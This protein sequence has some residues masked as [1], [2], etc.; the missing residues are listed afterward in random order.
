MKSFLIVFI[1]FLSALPQSFIEEKNSSVMV[2]IFPLKS[3]IKY[4]YF[5]NMTSSSGDEMFSR[6]SRDSGKVYYVVIDSTALNDTTIIWD[7]IQIQDFWRTQTSNYNQSDT[8]FK[9]TDSIKLILYEKKTG[10]HELQCSGLVWQFPFGHIRNE[11]H[12]S[13]FRYFDTTERLMAWQ[14][15]NLWG[16]AA[17]GSGTDS[18]FLSE[19]SGFYKR[20]FTENW[21][22]G[23]LWGNAT[24]QIYSLNDP[25]T[26][27]HQKGMMPHSIRLEQNYP[28][29]F[30][31]NTTI[32]FQLNRSAYVKLKVYNLLGKEIETLKDGYL[33]SGKHIVKWNAGELPTG[34]YFCR[35]SAGNYSEAI[36]L[37]LLK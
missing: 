1:L 22:S 5:I 19:K 16:I 12:E 6:S 36:K 3:G 10:N 28:N 15:Q 24:Y 9:V 31:P 13:V 23:Y 21:Y 2:D 37:V 18:V 17:H 7:V 30:N 8:T 34:I 20:Y 35:L 27:V 25:M 26:V 4:S 32:A 14:W 33:P 29:P 11:K